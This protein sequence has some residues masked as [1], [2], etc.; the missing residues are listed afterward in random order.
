VTF[1][2]VLELKR[3]GLIEIVQNEPFAPIHIGAADP[4]RFARV[5]DGTAEE[6]AEAD[7]R[8]LAESI[9][10]DGADE[11]PDETAEAAADDNTEPNP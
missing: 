2:A 1:I 6:V 3:E 7:G 5:I 11:P 10:V 4:A 8:L 9:A